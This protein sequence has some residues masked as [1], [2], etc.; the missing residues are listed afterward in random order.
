MVKI[1]LQKG[2]LSLQHSQPFDDDCEIGAVGVAKVTARAFFRCYN[3]GSVQDLI[4]SENFFGAKLH[5][6]VA[7]FTPIGIN[8]NLPARPF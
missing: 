3:D 7:A 5:T 8:K 6:D 2:I 4:E 1:N